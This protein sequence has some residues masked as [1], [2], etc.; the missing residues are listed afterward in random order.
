MKNHNPTPQE[1]V[2]ILSMIFARSEDERSPILSESPLS[3]KQWEPLKQAG[4]VRLEDGR[5]PRT[6]R[7]VKR[8]YLEDAAW[9]W[10]QEQ[11]RGP[12]AKSK[13]AARLLENVLG[14][15][16]DDLSRREETLASI[17]RT[18]SQLEVTP[19]TAP[20]AQPSGARATNGA[21]TNG[22]QKDAPARP[23]LPLPERVLQACSRLGGG[24]LR[25][26]ILLA[27]LRR[28]LADVPRDELDR[29]LLGL[30][31]QER[32][33]LHRLDNAMEVTPEDDRAA[34]S[35]AGNPRH[36]AYLEG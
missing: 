32:L 26:R 5:N 1:R 19:E 11:M 7:K 33:S 28:E 4:F 20:S 27:D 10:A 13:Y 22:A 35:I 6:G 17:A 8:V 31:E 3:G 30:Q 18:D 29:V 36:F 9:P 25:Q 14:L 2:A 15:L 16:A 12:L 24:K 23:S 21:R 34:L